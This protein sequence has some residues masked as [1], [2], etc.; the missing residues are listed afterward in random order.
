MLATGFALPWLDRY[1][2]VT[3]EHLQLKA[4]MLKQQGTDLDLTASLCEALP[5]QCGEVAS[6]LPPDPPKQKTRFRYS[7]EPC[8]IVAWAAAKTR[9]VCGGCMGEMVIDEAED[10]Q[11]KLNSLAEQG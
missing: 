4:K 2:P 10:F 11:V 8:A 3:V 6:I 9:M 7:C 5:T 1:T